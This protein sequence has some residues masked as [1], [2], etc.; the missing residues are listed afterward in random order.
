MCYFLNSARSPNRT[1]TML[2]I[3]AVYCVPIVDP[4]ALKRQDIVLA[5]SASNN[6]GRYSKDQ[7]SELSNGISNVHLKAGTRFSW[8]LCKYYQ[9]WH[10]HVRPSHNLLCDE[11]SCCKHALQGRLALRVNISPCNYLD[12]LKGNLI[13]YSSYTLLMASFASSRSGFIDSSVI[14]S[15]EK[16]SP[17]A[18]ERI[19]KSPGGYAK[20]FLQ[21]QHFRVKWEECSS[22]QWSCEICCWL[23]SWIRGVKL[24]CKQTAVCCRYAILAMLYAYICSRECRTVYGISVYRTIQKLKLFDGGIDEMPDEIRDS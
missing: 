23:F 7:K 11:T 1:S 21:I 17:S 20:Q 9:I 14:I 15:R 22:R 10:R 5:G 3:K 19:K 12:Q 13:A 8:Y 24:S 6:T 4:S 18:L 16:C 2:R